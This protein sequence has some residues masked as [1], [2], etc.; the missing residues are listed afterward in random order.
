MLL[1]C[2]RRDGLIQ[3]LGMGGGTHQ[4]QSAAPSLAVEAAPSVSLG[5][6]VLECLSTGS[7]SQ[8]WVG[9]IHF[10]PGSWP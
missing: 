9:D 8:L 4:F 7:W 10:L 3:M 6:L 1:T 5:L 2:K